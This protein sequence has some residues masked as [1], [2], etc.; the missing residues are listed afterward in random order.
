MIDDVEVTGELPAMMD[1]SVRFSGKVAQ[2]GGN[3]I[4]VPTEPGMTYEIQYT[5]HPLSN[6]VIWLPFANQANGVGRHVETNAG[7][8]TFT[9]VDDEGPQT[10][11]ES[12]RNGRRYYRISVSATP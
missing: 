3:Q 7:L 12:P 9:F 8:S 10:T 5:D 2:G 11:G 4:V 6:G 1:R